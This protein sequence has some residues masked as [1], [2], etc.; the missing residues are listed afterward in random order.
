M[1]LL[2]IPTLPLL[3]L[4]VTGDPGNTQTRMSARKHEALAALYLRGGEKTWMG[5]RAESD[6]F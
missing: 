3:K 2:R 6:G 5:R 4:R 1:Y